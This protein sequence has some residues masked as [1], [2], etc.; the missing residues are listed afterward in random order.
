MED[1]D[2]I[3]LTANELMVIHEFI[4]KYHMRD[5]TFVYKYD[6]DYIYWLLKKTNATFFGLTYKNVL[7]SLLCVIECSSNI[8]PCYK[9][10]FNCTN[11]KVNELKDVLITKYNQENSKYVIIYPVKDDNNMIIK[12]HLLPINIEHLVK[13]NFIEENAFTFNQPINN[14]LKAIKE[15]DTTDVKNILFK[16][17]ASMYFSTS[18]YLISDELQECIVSK[19]R[20][21]YSYII[22]D[23]NNDI[24]DIIIGKFFRL[25]VGNDSINVVKITYYV[26]YSVTTSDLFIYF[27]DKLISHNIDAIMYD[28]WQY[29]PLKTLDIDSDI[30]YNIPKNILSKS[31]LQKEK[32][33]IAD[34]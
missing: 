17:L 31:S 20:V 3:K 10:I 34:L 22:R 9:I 2:I 13:K 12:Q 21:I 16:S 18:Y 7:M 5:N 6:I 24:T 28:D 30:K 8:A 23:I 11:P 26:A 19:K 4:N 27:A 32:C 29:I 33:W 15:T 25:C 14:P 1:M